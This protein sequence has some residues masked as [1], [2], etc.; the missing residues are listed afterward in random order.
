MT[1]QELID[2]VSAMP[3][4]QELIVL[5]V[6]DPDPAEAITLFVH[7]VALPDPDSS[8]YLLLKS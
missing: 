2:K 6:T 3:R 5:D 1:V 8:V 7:E 4:E